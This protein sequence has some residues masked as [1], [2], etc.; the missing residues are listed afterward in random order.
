MCIYINKRKHGYEATFNGIPV[1]KD[2]N[3][4][5]ELENECTNAAIIAVKDMLKYGK[6]RED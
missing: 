6:Q 2:G 1:I 4:F 5:Y 3:R